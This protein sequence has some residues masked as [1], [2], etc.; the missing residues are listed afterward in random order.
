M[1][2]L[3]AAL[4]FSFAAS[5]TLSAQTARTVYI[6]ASSGNGPANWNNLAFNTLNATMLL[7]D[8]LTNATGIRAT[9]A[10]RL[11]GANANGSTSP[12][13]N[14]AE[15]APAGG[16]SSYGHSTYW[17]VNPPGVPPILFGEV[18][19]SNL[20][21]TVAYDFTFYASRMSVSDIRDARY[22]VT[23]SNSVSVVLN[24]S[25]NSNEVVVADDV[26]PDAAGIL[27]LRVE[28]GPN[29]NNVN[30]FYYITAMKFVYTDPP[31][32]QIYIDARDDGGAV[33][34]GWNVLDAGG[35][36][37]ATLVD[38]LGGATGIRGLVTT[39]GSFSAWGAFTP[40][41]DAAE[42]AP[43]GVGG[44]FTAGDT[45]CVM[46]F[47][48]LKPNLAYTFTFYANR[49]GVTDDRTTRYIVSGWNVGTNELNASS[50]VSN[51]TVVAG[52][53][54]AADRTI[55][56]AFRKGTGNTGNYNYLTAYKISYA[57]NGFPAP[58]WPV[59]EGKRL[60]FFGNQYLSTENV[61][62]LV[63]NL[64]VAGGYPRPFVFSDLGTDRALSNQVARV[65][66]YGDFNVNHPT[67][68]DTNT[69][70]HVVMQGHGDESSALGNAAAFRTNALALY[71]AVK[72]HASGKGAGAKAVLLQ[73]WARGAG[74]DLYPATFATP[75]AMQADI[76]AN[77]AA[78]TNA[79][80]VAEG[81]DSVRLAAAG[82]AF[83]T[84]GFDPAAL[85]AANLSTPGNVGPELAALTLYK[86]LYG[87]A[88]TD[89]PYD[90]AN[91]AGLVTINER[92]W[93]RITHWAEGL[94][95]PPAPAA[96][97]SGDLRVF[98]LDACSN[99]AGSPVYQGWNYRTFN[100]LGSVQLVLTNG[101][102]TAVTCEVLTRMN[103]T[104]TSVAT[105]TGDAAPFAQALA[106][107][108]FGNVNTWGSSTYSNEFCVVRF[109]GLG[110]LAS[111]TF[112]LYA[113]RASATGRETRY[114]VEGANNGFADLEPGNNS[115]EVAVIPS[116]RPKPDGTIDLKITAGPNNTS[117]EKFYHINALMIE[118]SR[119]GLLITVR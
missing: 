50:N 88:A 55:Q 106:N 36:N 73:T 110:T 27:T 32:T 115:T 57:D 76:D 63:A 109:S 86:A 18:T 99:P 16:N 35:A 11:N 89:I 37:A 112:T 13:G 21:P 69:W 98:L 4:L 67:L 38:S 77:T 85:Y 40:I 72:N 17:P 68:Y 56:V 28:A 41:G 59:M 92:D 49:P 58:E 44:A 39:P 12:T 6:D 64:A 62:N 30:G 47:Y 70:D 95:A 51:V 111:C 119:N 116:I 97:G 104:S 8:S 15:F 108:A 102:Q 46:T 3:L 1:G 24:S 91:A 65:D 26:Y 54:P 60:L 45:P 43:A 53:L 7:T 118:S 75:E 23:G 34:A 20:N 83:E 10:V 29:N 103:A 90:V 113:S 78:A 101:Y 107:N 74:A 117:V 71:Q 84:G 14:A 94:A 114:L 52:I 48:D 33:P 42:F 80:A 82:T 9:V 93:L 96:P 61:P 79:I 81:A 25:N 100:A 5:L 105:P 22:T 87:G 2:K 19:F 66:G 31:P